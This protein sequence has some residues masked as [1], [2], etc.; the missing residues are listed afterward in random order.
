MQN[1]EKKYYEKYKLCLHFI[2]NVILL[3]K[4]KCEYNKI[5]VGVLC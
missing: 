2:K 5:S 3:I 4:M 1:I